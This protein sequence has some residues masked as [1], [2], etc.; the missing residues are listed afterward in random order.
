[1]AD[2][3]HVHHK[4]DLAKV[5][6]YL[7]VEQKN[8]GAVV[9]RMAEYLKDEICGR[10]AAATPDDPFHGLDPDTRPEVAIMHAG[11][12]LLADPGDVY[13]TVAA[14][15]VRRLHYDQ[16]DAAARAGTGGS[17]AEEGADDALLSVEQ[18]DAM[19]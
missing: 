13:R 10:I 18:P 14:M 6:Q 4:D 16:L 9:T 3:D 2:V 5:G 15:P 7:R 12:R 1:M 19:V 17:D 8:K 11:Q